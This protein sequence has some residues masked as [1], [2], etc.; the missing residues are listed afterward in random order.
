MTRAVALLALLAACD[1]PVLPPPGQ[2]LLYFDTN[3]PLPAAPGQT[4]GS[5]A[6]LPI[7]D[8]LHVDLYLPNKRLPCDGCSREF[9]IDQGTVRAKDGG[10]AA[11]IG[12]PTPPHV[13]GY[14]VA[15]RLFRAASVYRNTIPDESSV[16]VVARLA[17]APAEGILEHTIFLDTETLGTPTGSLDAP[18]ETIPG[19]SKTSLE[20]TW[21]G[22]RRT[23]CMGTPLVDE[24]CVRGGA[25][26][27]GDPRL[28]EAISVT[29]RRTRL[30]VIAPFFMKKTEVTAGELRAAG[31]PVV[32]IP[33]LQKWCSYKD[34]PSQDD[35]RAANCIPYSVAQD[36]CK[37]RGGDFP[38]E[39]EFEFVAT[40]FNSTLY[41]W[42]NEDAKCDDAVWG[43]ASA[44]LNG[45]QRGPCYASTQADLP[46][47]PTDPDDGRR[48][49]VD[50][51]GEGNFIVDL[52]GNLAETMRDAWDDGKGCWS[53]SG[54]FRGEDAAHNFVCTRI[55]AASSSGR[56]GSWLSSALPAQTRTGEG[57]KTVVSIAV[58]FRCARPAAE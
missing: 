37:Q 30:V 29:E 16:I 6:P 49:K 8:R 22:A 55:G 9:A 42:G 38:S 28:A 40:A 3:A 21:D 4:L 41:P 45:G 34:P 13:G 46:A 57:V 1:H 54:I 14:R 52:I 51:S 25:Y 48:D 24:A 15:V 12:I 39:T 5:D 20:G 19:R 10:L 58:G 27:M 47:R 32:N 56:G 31:V 26:W 7:F 17:P 44:V 33:S 2:I 43:R 53:K 35:A 23:P 18:A 50:V 11:S 36:Y